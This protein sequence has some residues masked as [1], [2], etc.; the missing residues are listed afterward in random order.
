MNILMFKVICTL[1]K[2]FARRTSKESLKNTRIF[3]PHLKRTTPKGWHFLD[4][5][6]RLMLF[7][8]LLS[9]RT[10]ELALLW[11]GCDLVFDLFVRSGHFYQTRVTRLD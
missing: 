1:I 7:G 4:G 2:V 6:L 10:H 5:E 8:V 11:L 3:S 9:C